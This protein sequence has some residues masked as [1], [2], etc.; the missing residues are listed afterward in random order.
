MIHS[1]I[2]VNNIPLES[3][4]PKKLFYQLLLVLR[5][6]H[7]S[8]HYLKENLIQ[9]FDTMLEYCDEERDTKDAKRKRQLTT[10]KRLVTRY[11]QYWVNRTPE[12]DRSTSFIERQRFIQS[13]YDILLTLEGKGTLPNFGMSN[14]FGDKLIGNPEKQSIY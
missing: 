12:Y 3:T 6:K 1:V 7:S 2:R 8:L 5:I 10:L 11:K 9:I 13:Y 14:K 4:D